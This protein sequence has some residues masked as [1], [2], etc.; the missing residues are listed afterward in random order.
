MRDSPT[1]KRRWR[2]WEEVVPG[3]KITSCL[4]CKER[5][6]WAKT[7]SGKSMLMDAS[8]RPEGKW[9]TLKHQGQ[10]LAVPFKPETHGKCI[11]RE[12]HWATCV[13]GNQWQGK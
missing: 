6:F 11:R 1:E 10:V 12:E 13:E 4:S 5:V 2:P 3:V 9:V 7:L 8:A